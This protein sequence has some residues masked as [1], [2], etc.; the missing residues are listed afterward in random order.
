[1]RPRRPEYR[2][3]G[4][5][6]GEE[7][8]DGF[9]LGEPHDAVHDRAIG[10]DAYRAQGGA[11]RRVDPVA[12]VDRRP[13]HIEHDQLNHEFLLYQR[14]RFRSTKMD[15]I[16]LARCTRPPYWTGGRTGPVDGAARESIAWCLAVAHPP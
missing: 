3:G 7:A 5:R 11:K 2:D 6:G 16:A 13:G 15:C 10:L 12:V 14:A 4:P 9:R 8:A 1:M